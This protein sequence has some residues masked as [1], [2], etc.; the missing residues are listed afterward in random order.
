MFL[1]TLILRVPLK[2]TKRTFRTFIGDRLTYGIHI[3][4]ISLVRSFKNLGINRVGQSLG[5]PNRIHLFFQG[6]RPMKLKEATLERLSKGNDRHF[7]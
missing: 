6:L 3:P 4:L 2:T 5:L 7:W 1:P